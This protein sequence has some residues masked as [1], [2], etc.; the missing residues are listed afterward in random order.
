MGTQIFQYNIQRFP[1][2]FYLKENH[3]YNYF[4]VV[5]N[6]AKF[7]QINKNNSVVE[8]YFEQKIILKNS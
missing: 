2:A 3:I 4:L 6:C 8:Y 7:G 5:R 1:R